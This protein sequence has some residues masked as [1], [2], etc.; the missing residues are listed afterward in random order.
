MK[1]LCLHLCPVYPYSGRLA[2]CSRRIDAGDARDGRPVVAN[3]D[4]PDTIL[5]V[6]TPSFSPTKHGVRLLTCCCKMNRCRPSRRDKKWRGRHSTRPVFLRPLSAIRHRRPMRQSRRATCIQYGAAGLLRLNRAAVG[7]K[8][9][10]HC[11]LRY[12][13]GRSAVRPSRRR[14]GTRAE[15]TRIWRGRR[16]RSH[17]A[18]AGNT[19]R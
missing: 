5:S 13:T 7:S 11:P 18:P 9:S 14:A 2:S 4:S 6:T 10:E 15:R 16:A 19:V 3:L 8:S 17:G 12:G 1:C